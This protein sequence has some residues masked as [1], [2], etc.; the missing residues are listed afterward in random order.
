M[1]WISINE[2]LPELTVNEG[3]RWIS[4]YVLVKD[5]YG[6]KYTAYLQ[7]YIDVDFPGDIHPVKWI[8][9]GSDMYEGKFI[10]YWQPLPE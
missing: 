4:E 1:S 8:Q 3:Y 6:Q 2:K 7:Q 5:K 9:F 10:E